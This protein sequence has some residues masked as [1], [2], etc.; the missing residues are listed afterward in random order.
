MFNFG[1]AE[2]AVI[3][4]TSDTCQVEIVQEPHLHLGVKQGGKWIDPMSV[5]DTADI[6]E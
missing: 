6:A 5:I 4:V 1:L 2:G 3:G